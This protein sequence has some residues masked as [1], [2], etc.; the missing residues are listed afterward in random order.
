MDCFLKRILYNFQ[1]NNIDGISAIKLL[2]F[3]IENSNDEQTRVE[4]VISL[5]EVGIFNNDIFKFLEN[6]L[7]SDS[8][9]KVRN[10][11]SKL[12]KK[13]FSNNAFELL[14]WAINHETCFECLITII[15]TLVQINNQESKEVL[16]REIE[17]IMKNKFFDENKQIDNNKFKKNLKKLF[18][19]RNINDFTQNELAEIIVNYLTI[20]ILIKK[21]Y[22]VFFELEDGLVV[23]LD[24]SDVEYEVRGWKAEFKNN[25]E[26]VEEIEGLG[27]LKYLKRLDLSN[28]QIRNIKKLERLKSLTHLNLSNNKID[29]I[30]NLEHLKKLPNL[31]YLNLIGNKITDMLFINEFN[32]E[33][34]IVSKKSEY[35][36]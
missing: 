7:V 31:R 29:D 1:S 35:I 18:R 19:K 24:L 15:E 32:Q 30:E 12:I 8:S 2:I 4:S 11:A 13:K 21:F 10:A 22:S 25:I 14:K 34:E 6:L 20:S 23:E 9:C 3:M 33:L 36:Y 26:K 17:K 5:E 16:M 27:K 28:N